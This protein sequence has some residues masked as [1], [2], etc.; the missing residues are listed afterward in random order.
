MVSTTRWSQIAR[1]AA[2]QAD[3]GLALA[4]L[5]SVWRP[6]VLGWLR[7][8]EGDEADDLT[9][10]FLLFF[11]EHA[12]VA[13]A[14]P[15]R[16][17][18]RQ[19]MF[20]SLQHWWLD[21]CRQRKATK[22]GEGLKRSLDEARDAPDDADPGREFDRDWARQLLQR[23]YTQLAREAEQQGKTTLFREA[24]PFLAE[25]PDP[26]DYAEAA[27]RLGLRSNTFAAAVS[28]LRQRLRQAVRAEVA[29]TTIAAEDV[30]AE[31]RWLRAA[32]RD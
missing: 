29:D 4:E 17:R 25:S 26:T 19:F 20:S 21:R 28:R 5:C 11:L 23:A 32:L 27:A 8:R 31:M 3:A 24:A 30:E 16:G 13:R 14:D 15:S 9:Q 12:L 2:P 10:A 1:A 18:F 7:R 22:R 6:V